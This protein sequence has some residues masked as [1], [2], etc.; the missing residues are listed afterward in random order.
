MNE[1]KIVDHNL[2]GKK[3]LLI[4]A[5]EETLKK[6]ENVIELNCLDK[7]IVKE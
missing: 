1:V 5:D 6:I 2:L 7:K 3:S 4:I